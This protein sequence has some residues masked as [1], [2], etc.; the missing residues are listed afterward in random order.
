MAKKTLWKGVG[1]E[2]TINLK[3]FHADK[4]VAGVFSHK[5]SVKHLCKSVVIRRV[6]RVLNRKD[7]VCMIFLH[8]AFDKKV[9]YIDHRF[10]MTKEI[11]ETNISDI[12]YSSSVGR[13]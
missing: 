9:Y 2:I 7:K 13:D 8:E 4:L 6:N 12:D 1:S 3:Y 10:T 5:T 11:P